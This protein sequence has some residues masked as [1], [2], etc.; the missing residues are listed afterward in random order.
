MK[1]PF[2]LQA[3]LLEKRLTPIEVATKLEVHI[4]TI[5]KIQKR[6]TVKMSFLKLLETH[7]GDCSQ[8][9]R[10]TVAA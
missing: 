4:D 6:G 2:D 9:I 8:F 7:F 5:Y 3:F 10:S 1:T